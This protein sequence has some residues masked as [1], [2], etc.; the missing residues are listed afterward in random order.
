MMIC[1]IE[2]LLLHDL[3][4]IETMNEE[5][6]RTIGMEILPKTMLA[7]TCKSSSMTSSIVITPTASS[8]SG[9]FGS[10]LP[11]I[12]KMS[13][14]MSFVHFLLRE[15]VPY[16][17]LFELLGKLF[18]FCSGLLVFKTFSCGGFSPS[19]SIFTSLAEPIM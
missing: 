4:N 3:V 11:S 17:L 6:C 13:E 10:G 16:K 8:S 18:H 2:Y 7:F 12:C 15:L 5:S 19:M 14:Y 9:S 1:L